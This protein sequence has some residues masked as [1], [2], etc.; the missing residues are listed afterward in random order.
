MG[1]YFYSQCLKNIMTNIFDVVLVSKIVFCGFEP[2]TS[3][4]IMYQKIKNAGA[5]VSVLGRGK[6]KVDFEV[7]LPGIHPDQFR[8]QVLVIHSGDQFVPEI[9]PQFFELQHGDEQYDPWR[10]SIELRSGAGHFGKKGIYYYRYQLQRRDGSPVLSW[11]SDPFAKQSG[12][13]TLSAFSVPQDEAF[14]WSGKEQDYRTPPLNDLV[15]YECMVDEFA[16]TFD[17]LRQRL[18]YIQGL[19]VNC[20]ELMPV[21]NCR[22]SFRWGYMPLSHFAIEERYGGV[23]G[24]KR[25]IS[26]CHM[27]GVAVIH[28][29]VYAHAHEDFLY[30]KLYWEA[31]VPNPMMGR[32]AEDMF[33]VGPD[34]NKR[35]TVDYFTAVNSY[36]LE[37]LHFDG[38]R[39]DYV[40]GFYAGPAKPGYSALVYDTYNA[41]REI[42]RFATADGKSNVIQVAEFLADPSH[43]MSETFSNSAKRWDLMDE[44]QVSMWQRRPTERFVDELLLTSSKWQAMHP[45]GE[46]PVAPLQFVETHDKSRLMLYAQQA[47]V[48][49]GG[50]DFP[51]RGQEQ[52]YQT[53]PVAIGLM[54]APGVPM[55]WQGQEFGETYGL[56]GEGYERVLAG[57]PLNWSFF[58]DD[59]GKAMVDLYR[60]L[61]KAR[62]QYSCLRSR[63]VY[64]ENKLSN[65]CDGVMVYRRFD[66]R[67]EA[68]VVLN[69]S[70][71]ECAVSIPMRQGRWAEALYPDDRPVLD[72][73]HDGA[74]M[75]IPVPSH[76]G[77]VYVHQS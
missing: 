4:I 61:G 9:Q 42:L 77:T 55:I 1:R 7:F 63:N 32:F 40:P 68:A 51:R 56:P 5:S 19:G 71:R 53:Q 28:D 25:L 58:Y 54:T 62:Q 3:G 47:Q 72:S 75:S 60:R 18:D 45:Y 39:Y 20:I 2:S 13:G 34:F 70:D 10:A 27:R 29:A 38:F 48:R 73:P 26:E 59:A 30:N 37:E 14:Q 64:Y 44:A 33:G 6:H 17:G 49:E 16:E 52:W 21:T 65:L 31:Q 69:F 11:I 67:G 8:L 12:P 66:D 35:F 23:S 76:F 50:F 22:E 74:A 43:I 24:L 15:V 57:R 36:Y 46:F 41:S